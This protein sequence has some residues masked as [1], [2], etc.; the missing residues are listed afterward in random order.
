M[1]SGSAAGPSALLK[2]QHGPGR[3]LGSTQLSFSQTTPGLRLGASMG[4]GP[5]PAGTFHVVSS[6]WVVR[7][8]HAMGAGSSL[9]PDSCPGRASLATTDI[10]KRHVCPQAKGSLQLQACRP[11][12]QH[13]CLYELRQSKNTHD[14]ACP[15]TSSCSHTLQST[16]Q[17]V[18]HWQG[19]NIP[20]CFRVGQTQ[21]KTRDRQ[22]HRWGKQKVCPECHTAAPLPS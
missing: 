4:Q 11:C 5:F 10:A 20:G 19:K 1:F 3:S 9:E 22:S 18:A 8:F 16:S 6:V 7:G 15:G 14:P 12:T 13:I 21:P 2:W 17:E